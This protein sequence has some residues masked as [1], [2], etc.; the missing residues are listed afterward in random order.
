MLPVHSVFIFIAKN[1]NPAVCIILPGLVFLL[2]PA[3]DIYNPTHLY[4]L[5][6]RNLNQLF[7]WSYIS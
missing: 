4:G 5:I 7:V 2:V 1:L 3:A 6:F